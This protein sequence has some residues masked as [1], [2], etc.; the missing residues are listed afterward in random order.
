MPSANDTVSR[1]LGR[2]V[3]AVLVIFLVAGTVAIWALFR[4]PNEV[5]RLAT[6]YGPASDAN[7]AALTYMLDAETAI[8]GFALSGE[9]A[10]L[11][12][13]RQAVRKIVP[14]ID[15]VTKALHEVDNHSLD[16]SVAEQRLLAQRWITT[17]VRPA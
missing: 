8:R 2:V 10:S 16:G 11:G 9:P 15:S 5:D 3:I 4:S 17:I 7:A 13:Y 6:A 12:P 1:R 14:T